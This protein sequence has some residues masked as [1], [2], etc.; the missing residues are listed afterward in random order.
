MPS[1]ESLPLTQCHARLHVAVF[2]SCGVSIHLDSWR[3]VETLSNR[4]EM[5]DMIGTVRFE[6]TM[7][8]SGWTSVSAVSE[9]QMQRADKS[10]N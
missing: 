9:G 6:G 10:M 8:C 2:G 7:A 4:H 1:S 5:G 3:T